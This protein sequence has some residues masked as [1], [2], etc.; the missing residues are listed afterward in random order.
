MELSNQQVRTPYPD[1]TARTPL[2]ACLL[3][4]APVSL[5]VLSLIAS[6]IIWSLKKQQWMDEVFTRIELSDPSPMHL[7]HVSQFLGGAGMPLFYL[8]GW[9]WARIFGNSDLSLRL[10]SCIAFCAAFYVLFS[11]FRKRFGARPAFLGVGISLLSS[12]LVLNQNAEARGYGLYFLFAALAV[13]IWLK[14]AETSRPSRRS[15]LY[16]ALAQAGLVLTHVL[17]LIFGVTMLVALVS[18]DLLHRRFRPAVYFAHAIGWTTLLLWLPAIRASAAAG[19]PHSW[20]APP[21]IALL[22]FELTH[23]PFIAFSHAVPFVELVTVSGLA[24]ILWL[25]VSEFRRTS[26][27]APAHNPAHTPAIILALALSAAPFAFFLASY[28]ITPIFVGRYML[29]S[30]IGLTLL[31]ASWLSR[32]PRVTRG[33]PWTLLLA[34]TLALPIA[35]AIVYQPAS[36]NVAAIDRLS[37]SQPLVCEQIRDF[38]VMARYSRYPARIEYP[39]D[40]PAALNGRRPDVTSYHLLVNYRRAGYLASNIWNAP[41][42]LAQPHFFLLANLDSNWFRYRIASNPA[43]TWRPVL[44]LDP[45]HT[46]YEVWRRPPPAAFAHPSP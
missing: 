40:W 31:L 1:A 6:C 33:L 36:L 3:G 11:A 25:A 16:L 29:P 20:I 24:F 34:F 4:Y 41:S 45:M 22:L 44:R 13:A 30:L 12:F 37:A 23:R 15:L 46:L 5:A 17:G 9:P 10:Y 39:L 42:I 43:F 35:S 19:K 32:H 28:L 27:S 21:N 38:L 14:V 7:L 8:T 26:S 2:S 18:S